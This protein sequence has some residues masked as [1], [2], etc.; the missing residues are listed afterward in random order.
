MIRYGSID[1][2]IDKPNG[3]VY[4]VSRLDAESGCMPTP[5]QTQK[6]SRHN[7]S[8][9]PIDQAANAISTCHDDNIS[10]IV[11]GSRNRCP[12]RGSTLGSLP[13]HRSSSFSASTTTHLK[14]TLQLQPLRQQRASSICDPLS[15][16]ETS[17]AQSAAM[18]RRHSSA[19]F[20]HDPKGVMS[21]TKRSDPPLLSQHSVFSL[22][23]EK[24]TGSRQHL[25]TCGNTLGV[26]AV[27]S[28]AHTPDTGF[29]EGRSSLS[30]YAHS[31]GAV[32]DRVLHHSSTSKGLLS[33]L[34]YSQ[35]RQSDRKQQRQLQKQFT[36][37]E[38]E[39]KERRAVRLFEYIHQCDREEHEAKLRLMVRYTHLQRIKIEMNSEKIQQTQSTREAK[40]IQ[41]RHRA[42][43]QKRHYLD[44]IHRRKQK[45]VMACTVSRPKPDNSKRKNASTWAE[46]PATSAYSKAD[47]RHTRVPAIGGPIDADEDVIQVH[48]EKNWGSTVRTASILG[49][50]PFGHLD[51][52]GIVANSTMHLPNAIGVAAEKRNT[53]HMSSIVKES[54]EIIVGKGRGTQLSK[55]EHP[56]ATNTMK[57]PLG[58]AAFEIQGKLDP[59]NSTGHPLCHENRTTLFKGKAYYSQAK[60]V[61]EVRTQYDQNKSFLQAQ[62]KSFKPRLTV[63]AVHKPT[64]TDGTIPV[65]VERR[66]SRMPISNSLQSSSN[67]H[68]IAQFKQRCIKSNMLE[69]KKISMD[70]FHSDIIKKSRQRLNKILKMKDTVV[71]HRQLMQRIATGAANQHGVVSSLSSNYEAGFIHG[72]S[73]SEMVRLSRLTTTDQPLRVALTEKPSLSRSAHSRKE[74][75]IS[76]EHRH[77][78]PDESVHNDTVAAYPCVQDQN[79]KKEMGTGMTRSDTELPISGPSGS[80]GSISVSLKP[81]INTLQKQL[82]QHQPESRAQSPSCRSSQ[83]STPPPP[84]THDGVYFTASRNSLASDGDSMSKPT[85]RGDD[86]QMELETGKD[87]LMMDAAERERKSDQEQARRHIEDM[88][89]A[90]LVKGRRGSMYKASAATLRIVN[91]RA[92]HINTDAHDER[93]NSINDDQDD[94]S[95]LDATD[96]PQTETGSRSTLMS[97]RVIEGEESGHIKQEMPFLAGA[98][99]VVGHRLG[100]KKSLGSA[101]SSLID[102]DSLGYGSLTSPTYSSHSVSLSSGDVLSAGKGSNLK[103]SEHGASDGSLSAPFNQKAKLSC[104]TLA[105]DCDESNTYANHPIK[106]SVQATPECLDSPTTSSMMKVNSTDSPVDATSIYVSRIDEA[107]ELLE[108]CTLPTR[109]RSANRLHHG[110]GNGRSYSHSLSS[111]AIVQDTITPNR[112]R[113]DRIAAQTGDDGDDG[114]KEGRSQAPWLHLDMASVAEFGKTIWPTSYVNA[115]HSQGTSADSVVADRNHCSRDQRCTLTVAMAAEFDS[116]TLG[117]PILESKA[118]ME[119]HIHNPMSLKSGSMLTANRSNRSSWDQDQASSKQRAVRLWHGSRICISSIPLDVNVQSNEA[120]SLPKSSRHG[121]CQPDTNH[122]KEWPS[123]VLQ[124]VRFWNPNSPADQH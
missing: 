81:P 102:T 46:I 43:Q 30:L 118:G 96:T 27:G 57:M 52:N 16:L 111:L 99:S 29:S 47:D 70:T 63:K 122:L 71:K 104:H 7:S 49:N 11:P 41:K 23:S 114:N 80:R 42:F 123:L 89:T 54:K 2:G 33:E 25:R 100:S 74:T 15:L 88:A 124:S 106:A 107:E 108:T 36:R 92:M 26:K 98:E 22:T 78:I 94:M 44:S 69:S 51:E 120:D 40:E 60:D 77:P 116:K 86:Q 73:E 34:G 59:I 18:T 83:S 110:R 20:T 103:A 39:A 76:N 6:D 35:K 21:L 12:T 90:G 19:M 8:A 32:L 56:A 87:S 82:Y 105:I 14:P 31:T 93:S 58:L 24:S 91:Q 119:D 10:L 62:R 65:S 3:S 13:T 75:L 17:L 4:A 117:S 72:R 97:S 37:Q 84:S 28:G 112:L 68:E 67:S 64:T 85:L 5:Q 50:E 61:K 66:V 79:I 1:V 48:K 109:S 121:Q 55:I 115:V 9:K 38:T 53:T 45:P 113:Q 95:P 101:H